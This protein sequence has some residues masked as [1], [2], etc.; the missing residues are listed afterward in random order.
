MSCSLAKASSSGRRAMW[1]LSPITSQ[2]TAA[3]DRP[4]RRTR[5]IAPSV[6]AIPDKHSAIGRPQ[7]KDMAGRHDGAGLYVG[8]GCDADRMRPVVGRNAGGDAVARLDGDG[9]GG[10]AAGAVHRHH[11]VEA[12]PVDL[13]A[14]ERQ[15]DQPA[16]LP[17]HE[18]DGL[19]CGELGGDHEVALVLSVLVID[20]QDHAA[21]L[22][23]VQCER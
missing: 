11:W 13:L 8:G 22:Q 21:G 17:G 7:R 23:P 18:S 1:P 3:G 20:E 10:G 15:A 2:M 4:A 6:M 14:G 16:G 19:R 12:E 5:S 9:E